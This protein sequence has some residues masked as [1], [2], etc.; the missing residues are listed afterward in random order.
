MDVSSTATANLDPRTMR[1]YSGGALTKCSSAS[2]MDATS[3]VERYMS[4][5]PLLPREFGSWEILEEPVPL[6][7][8]LCVSCDCSIAFIGTGLVLYR[9][10]PHF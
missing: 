10:T 3:A 4:L 7:S 1:H 2:V 5:P 8:E 9:N 6:L